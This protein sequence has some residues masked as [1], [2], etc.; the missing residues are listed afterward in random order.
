VL[1][2]VTDTV[3]PTSRDAL[4]QRVDAGRRQAQLFPQAYFVTG[5]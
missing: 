3:P 1:A 4:L 2:R 5:H